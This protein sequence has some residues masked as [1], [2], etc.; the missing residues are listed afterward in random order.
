MA[1]FMA[2]RHGKGVPPEKEAGDACRGKT[3]KAA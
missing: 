2:F 1:S 3:A